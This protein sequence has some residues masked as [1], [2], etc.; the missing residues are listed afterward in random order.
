MRAL[1]RLY[2]RLGDT[3]RLLLWLFVFYFAADAVVFRWLL[4]RLPNES[5]WS[6]APFY[7]FEYRARQL[8][9]DKAPNEFRVLVA[10]SS[11]A[12]YS[13]IPDRLDFALQD[14]TSVAGTAVDAKTVSTR[15]LAHQGLSGMHLLA[16]ADRFIEA[17]PDV[18]V[19]PVNMVDFRLE[20]IIANHDLE[21]LDSADAELRRAALDR[22]ERYA[23]SKEEFEILAPGPWVW[24]Y[25]RLLNREQHASAFFSVLSAAYRYRKIALTPVELY[26]DNRFSS[27]R[28]YE[29]YAGVAVGGGGISHRGWTGRDFR[30]PLTAKFQ[31]DGLLLQAPPELFAAAAEAVPQL[32]L[33]FVNDDGDFPYGRRSIALRPGWQR[34]DLQEPDTNKATYVEL[35]LSHVWR[36]AEKADEYGVR[37]SRNAGREEV[38]RRDREIREP[39]R[40]DQL[41]L[42]YDDAQYRRSFDERILGF[43]RAGTEYLE[44]LKLAKDRF[45]GRRFDAE[46]PAFAAFA[47]FRRRMAEAGIPL[48]IVNSPENPIS[49]AWYRDSHWYEGYLDFLRNS[50]HGGDYWFYD[51]S[52]LLKMQ[53]FYD[54]HHLSYPGARAFSAFLAGRLLAVPDDA[55]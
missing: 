41:Y 31:Q 54:Y 45:R 37:L 26:S 47:A 11:I 25:S 35:R 21:N 30:I 46:L 1:F 29:E 36:S 18:L 2:S 24:H 27:G 39:R 4:W 8:A 40:E 13:V 6:E 16:Y 50:P 51:A 43:E 33:E 49:L 3:A 53:M 12:L 52:A 55:R 5:A 22:A 7:N 17:R 15:I 20:R 48:V 38:Y 10:G 28:S 42:S 19:V 34:I 14:A 44:A 23:V 9:R 32:S